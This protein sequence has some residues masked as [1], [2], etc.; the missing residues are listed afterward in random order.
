[1]SRA[2]RSGYRE[3]SECIHELLPVDAARLSGYD[4][5]KP[6]VYRMRATVAGT[7][8]SLV[9]KRSSAD[10]ARRNSLVTGR[11]LPAAG[12][13][14]LGPP[15]IAF[16]VDRTGEY[17]W[18]LYDDLPGRPLAN[19]RPVLRDVEAAIEAVARLHTALAAHPILHECRLWGGDRGMAF[20]SGNVRDAIRAL[21]SLDLRASSS[22]A[23]APRAALL[24]RLADLETEGAQRAGALAVWGGPETLIHGDLWTTNVIVVP[25]G[26]EIRVR[27]IDW[28]EAAV[29]SYS[30][31][32]STLL[33]RFDDSERRWILDAY[34]RAVDRIAGWRLP[35][36]PELSSILETAAY[37][38]LASLLVWTVA[39]A[40][41][42]DSEWLADF[43]GD[44]VGWLDAVRPVVPA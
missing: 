6:G 12:L 44:M 29:G 18:Q 21:R 4:Q 2:Q 20:F 30:F 26:E 38:R 34:R 41:D 33:L 9:L 39:S 15:L 17:A 42:D 35:P 7:E 31:D 14:E 22:R 36:E 5:L 37:A 24:E 32:I 11:W 27:L 16:M 43:L 28:D 40:H 23:D 1:M 25:D 3:L 10:A 13:A 8:R 19:E